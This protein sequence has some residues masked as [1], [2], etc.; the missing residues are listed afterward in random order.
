MLDRLYLPVLGVATAVAIV[1]AL[2]WP[3]GQGA[4]SPGPFG[5]TPEQQTPQM[6][7][8]IR[9]ENDAA[10]QR[11][12]QARDTVRTLQSQAIAPGQ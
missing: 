7:A 10:A 2:L 1:L 5:R 8:A 12:H 4:R 6:Q 9:R 3:Q 11:L